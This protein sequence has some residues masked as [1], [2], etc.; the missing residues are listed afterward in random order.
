MTIKNKFKSIKK[1]FSEKLFDI[2]SKPAS[3]MTQEKLI[4]YS[5]ADDVVEMVQEVINR[6]DEAIEGIVESTR[7]KH[8]S[9]NSKI[10]ANEKAI[11]AAALVIQQTSIASKV[12]QG[13]ISNLQ[14]S[15]TAD[16]LDVRSS[17]TT[18]EY[19]EIYFD[20]DYKICTIEQKL[21]ASLVHKY[22]RIY[23][24]GCLLM[25][26]GDYSLELTDK[27]VKVI[28][29]ESVPANSSILYELVKNI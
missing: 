5:K 26:G 25:Y 15:L 20:G 17:T 14:E 11:A 6:Y 8:T 1:S 19:S 18:V 27:R 4:D 12:M 24:D 2:V 3:K 23:L 7:Q 28:F 9:I 16:R 29:E 10:D 13:L 21:H 22:L